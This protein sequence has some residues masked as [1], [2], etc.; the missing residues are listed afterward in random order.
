MKKKVQ[1]TVQMVTPRRELG[2]EAREFE[3]EDEHV[4][5]VCCP[6]MCSDV[7]HNEVIPNA[8]IE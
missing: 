1:W 8:L 7:C 3:V 4:Y 5:C 2:A 6:R